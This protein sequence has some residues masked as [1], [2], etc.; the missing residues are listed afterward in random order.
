MPLQIQQTDGEYGLVSTKSVRVG[1]APRGTDLPPRLAKL[2][3]RFAQEPFAARDIASHLGG[4]LRAANLL[5]AEGIRAGVL[6]KSG[7]ARATRYRF[8]IA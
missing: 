6:E 1:F 2:K 4:S 7:K 3:K 5:A 8:R